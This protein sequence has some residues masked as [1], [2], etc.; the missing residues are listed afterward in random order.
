[1][2]TLNQFAPAAMAGDMVYA[3]NRPQ[4]SVRVASDQSTA[5]VAGQAIKLVD[6]AGDIPTI[7]AAAITE[8]PYGVVLRSARK[9]S[10]AANTICSIARDGDV[11]FMTTAGAVAGGANV[12][13]TA[14]AKVDDTTTATSAFLGKALV[15]QATSGGLVPVEICCLAG[16]Q[17]APSTGA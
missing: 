16:L 11:V 7:A 15:K 6:V 14:D 5:L 3:P 1:M 12:Q 4:L 10:F 8:R 17:A 2:T 13:F 9:T